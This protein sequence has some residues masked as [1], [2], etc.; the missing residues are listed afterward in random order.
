MSLIYANAAARQLG[1]VSEGM[2]VEY[3]RKRPTMRAKVSF[4]RLRLGP[5]RAEVCVWGG[6]G[7]REQWRRQYKGAKDT[8]KPW[9]VTASNGGANTKRPTIRPKGEES[10]RAMAVP[11]RYKQ[12][13]SISSTANGNAPRRVLRCLQQARRL[14][15]APACIL[16]LR[17][18]TRRS[19]E[20]RRPA[21]LHWRRHCSQ[22]PAK[23]CKGVHGMQFCLHSFCLEPISNL[24]PF[25]N[26]NC[27][28]F[29]LEM[30]K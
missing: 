6:G 15:S 19:L 22:W 13:R 2:R 14:L 1:A 10:L 9:G 26:T 27:I 4:Q 21:A 5:L 28:F 24:G 3:T 23:C 29:I 16:Q 11:I 17:I 8:S 12:A 18:T 20:H 30:A 7:H 25:P